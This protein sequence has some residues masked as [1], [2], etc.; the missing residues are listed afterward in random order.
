M[1]DARD[2]AK[3]KKADEKKK[4]RASR[5]P[6]RLP[7]GEGCGRGEASQEVTVVQ[8]RIG[9]PDLGTRRST[10]CRASGSGHS[11]ATPAT[12]CRRDQTSPV[13]TL[14]AER[15]VRGSAAV[16]SRRWAASRLRVVSSTV[17]GCDGT[18]YC[19]SEKLRGQRQRRPGQLELVEKLPE[20]RHPQEHALVQFEAVD[21]PVFEEKAVSPRVALGIGRGSALAEP[22]F[23]G[24][25]EGQR[26]RIQPRRA[27]VEHRRGP[28]GHLRL[29][30]RRDVQARDRRRKAGRLKLWPER[31][32]AASRG[33]TGEPQART[34]SGSPR[35]GQAPARGRRGHSR[36]RAGIQGI[37]QADRRRG[38]SGSASPTTSRIPSRTSQRNAAVRRSPLRLTETAIEPSPLAVDRRDQRTNQ[39]GRSL[40]AIELTE[41]SPQR[42]TDCQSSIR[43]PRISS[44]GRIAN[45]SSSSAPVTCPSLGRLARRRRPAP[46][47]SDRLIGCAI[48]SLERRDCRRA[49]RGIVCA[50]TTA[51]VAC[52]RPV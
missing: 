11:F 19:S 5:R 7:R 40:S 24:Q 26:R 4:A 21:E 12:A 23:L 10:K 9:R 30:D 52:L 2:T 31:F 32:R 8:Q 3:K 49:R 25:L 33:R 43:R 28:A 29:V 38:D 51:G 22:D 50:K 37:D 14:T 15:L 42:G 34:T 41:R 47:R 36:P 46:G 18:A 39:P 1:G 6:R 35:A 13:S 27:R 48:D 45:P 16:R 20:P 44:V 17:K